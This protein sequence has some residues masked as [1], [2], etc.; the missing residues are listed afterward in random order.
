MQSN[1]E[2]KVRL[3]KETGGDKWDE[4]IKAVFEVDKKENWSDDDNRKVATHIA[5]NM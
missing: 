4:L 5:N 3:M 1:A 2:K